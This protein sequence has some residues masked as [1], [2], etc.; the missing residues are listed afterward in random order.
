MSGDPAAAFQVVQTQL[1]YW[2]SSS[3]A[4]KVSVA[5]G[6][7]ALSAVTVFFK[8]NGKKNEKNDGKG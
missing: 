1:S 3:P 7:A 8:R 6:A 2:E 5:L 4:V